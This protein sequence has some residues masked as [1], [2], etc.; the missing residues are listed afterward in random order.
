MKNMIVLLHQIFYKEKQ[1]VCKR[2]FK[3]QISNFDNTGA[4]LSDN[5]IMIG[6]V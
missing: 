1:H 2:T 4:S 3:K 6:A 5:I